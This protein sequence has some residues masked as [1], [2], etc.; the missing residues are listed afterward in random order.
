M[1][2]G[3][4]LQSHAKG[5][6]FPLL[7]RTNHVWYYLHKTRNSA[8]L[9]VKECMPCNGDRV[10]KRINNR[11]LRGK[12]WYEAAEKEYGAGINRKR[13]IYGMSP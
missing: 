3:D 8:E 7:K 2:L 10:S 5:P 13:K 11:F 4:A 6:K 9:A 12:S 1:S